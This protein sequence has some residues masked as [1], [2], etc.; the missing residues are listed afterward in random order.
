VCGFWILTDSPYLHVGIGYGPDMSTWFFCTCPKMLRSYGAVSWGGMDIYLMRYD[1]NARRYAIYFT[2]TIPVPVAERLNVYVC[3]PDT[4]YN[5]EDMKIED[6]PDS[7]A[8]IIH[9]GMVTIDIV[10]VEEFLQ[11][12]WSLWERTYLKREVTALAYPTLR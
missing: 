6:V 5:I 10:D 1:D 9:M 7:T 11:S 12:I 2:P 3:L 4:Y 8:R